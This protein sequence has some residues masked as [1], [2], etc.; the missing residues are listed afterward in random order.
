[1][2]N[3]SRDDIED[4]RKEWPARLARVLR[5]RNRIDTRGM[6]RPPRCP[7]KREF[8]QR[9]GQLGPFQESQGS[10]GR[11]EESGSPG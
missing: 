8:L 1:M 10:G 9:T 6:T 11:P 3:E 4:V 5:V 7:I 2:K